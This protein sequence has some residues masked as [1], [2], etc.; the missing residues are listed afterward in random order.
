M[1]TFIEH[2]DEN[3][4]II[5]QHI[6][7]VLISMCMCVSVDAGVKYDTSVCGNCSHWSRPPPSSAS[8]LQETYKK[9]SFSDPWGQNFMS[10]YECNQNGVNHV[11]MKEWV[12]CDCVFLMLLSSYILMETRF[13][14]LSVGRAILCLLVRGWFGFVIW[15]AKVSD[16]NQTC[17]Q[18]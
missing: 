7:F 13:T 8:S 17:H 5:L 9:V 3:I 18:Q 12:W 10:S 4:Q 15:D 16:L 1:I 2:I 14:V 11:N 6:K